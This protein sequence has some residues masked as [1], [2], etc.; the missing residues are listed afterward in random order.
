[1]CQ[2]CSHLRA[3]APAVPSA[4]NALPPDLCMAGCFLSLAIISSEKQRKHLLCCS[5]PII[6][7][8][9]SSTSLCIMLITTWNFPLFTGFIL[10]LP[11]Q[12][13]DLSVMITHCNP[14]PK[15]G[16]A[17]NWCSMSICWTNEWISACMTE[18]V[19]NWT[20][21]DFGVWYVKLFSLTAP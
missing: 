4:R 21:W 13:R 14:Y 1:M 20:A 17:S 11:Y 10:Y 3:S 19:N 6:V 9:P 15:T 12:S 8:S 16:L 18:E 2:T 7:T 5:H